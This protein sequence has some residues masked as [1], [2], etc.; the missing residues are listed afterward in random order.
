[1][2]DSLNSV[3]LKLSSDDIEYLEE[4]YIA[5]N[6]VGVMDDNKTTSGDGDKVLQKFTKIQL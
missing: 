2:E 5:H 4:P 6:S 1:M 3:D